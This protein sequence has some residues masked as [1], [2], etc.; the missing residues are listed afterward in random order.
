MALAGM[1]A[2]RAHRAALPALPLAVVGADRDVQFSV[3]ERMSWYGFRETT[4]VEDEA[5][6][7]LGL[8]DVHLPPLDGE[9][10]NAFRRPQAAGDPEAV[11]GHDAL[12][13]V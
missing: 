10:R 8:F 11:D 9:G 12:C 4:R 13:V 5:Y 6:C 2:A 3:A 1:D 7:L